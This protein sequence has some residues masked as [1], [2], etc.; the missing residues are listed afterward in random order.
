[1]S[2]RLYGLCGEEEKACG[3]LMTELGLCRR[4]V[5]ISFSGTVMPTHFEWLNPDQ[6][7]ARTPSWQALRGEPEYL[8]PHGDVV[9][10]NA[11]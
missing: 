10:G 8:R 5:K 2:Q 9:C 7:K 6:T 1:M 11:Q 4:K 3:D